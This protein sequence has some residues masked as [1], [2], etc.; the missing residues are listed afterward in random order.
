MFKK[1]WRLQEEVSEGGEGGGAPEPQSPAMEDPEDFD[2]SF[3]GDTF[4]EEQKAP[5]PAPAQPVS[6]PV[7]PEAPA[8]APSEAPSV[9]PQVAP[10]EPTVPL[11]PPSP[12]V[13]PTPEQ[14]KQWQQ[15]DFSR[16]EKSYAL[17]EEE[18]A[19]LL[20]E[21]EKV[22]PK[23]AATLHQQIRQEM[24]ATIGQIVPHLA[25][26]TQAT[27]T[28]EA[29]AKEQ[30]FSKWPGL[31]K[32]EQQV[33]QV[34]AMYRQMNPTAQGDAV[35]DAV[36]KLVAGALGM[37]PSAVGTAPPA[38]APTL[39]QFRPS[40]VGSAGAR[41]APQQNPFAALAAQTFDDD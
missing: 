28:R 9:A 32:H 6:A 1:M 20:T 38:Q 19:S 24:L 12:A 33:L 27:D 25:R 10:A 34:G 15:E 3:I 14:V 7:V 35:V 37:D 5:E 39:S 29:A 21:P 13:G 40:G 26:Q 4:L 31:R 2:E 17:P 36:G 16:L 22:L 11:E 41:P 23:L 8:P 18:V 30:F